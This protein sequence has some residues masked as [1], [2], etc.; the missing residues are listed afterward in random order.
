ML[1]VH[2]L[3]HTHVVIGIAAAAWICPSALTLISGLQVL[4]SYMPSLSKYSSGFLGNFDL[5]K[6]TF[7][8]PTTTPERAE[9]ET[10]FFS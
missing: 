8:V 7:Q 3:D 5:L 6:S 2:H 10:E 9:G 1:V 4:H